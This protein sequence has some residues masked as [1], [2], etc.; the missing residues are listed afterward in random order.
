MKRCL[1]ER[2]LATL[3]A[4]GGSA[5]ERQHLG[6]CLA[7]RGR[8][9]ALEREMEIAC[10]ALRLGPPP[11]DSAVAPRTPSAERAG[12]WRLRGW[13]PP[14][15]PAMTAAAAILT[16]AVGWMALRS[17]PWSSPGRLAAGGPPAA[18]ADDRHTELATAAREISAALFATGDGR[19]LA[20][21][22]ELPDYLQASAALGGAWP[23]SDGD[24]LGED[25][26]MQ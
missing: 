16:I 12:S 4:G 17:A 22:D 15:T 1:G 8:Y 19:R 10:G 13:L 25:C 5:A 24:G 26:V 2:K 6:A 9:R 18:I 3:F 20:L 21:R 7:C 14:M 23:C 11:G